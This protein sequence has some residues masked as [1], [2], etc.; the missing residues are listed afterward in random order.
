MFENEVQKPY[1]N[2][3]TTPLLRSSANGAKS[4]AHSQPHC[5]YQTER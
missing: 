5:T 3:P 1:H 4:N 2:P